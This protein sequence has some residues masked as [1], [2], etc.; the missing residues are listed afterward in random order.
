MRRRQL[1]LSISNDRSYKRLSFTSQT[2]RTNA[3]SIR[4]RP[5]TN[6]PVMKT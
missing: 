2:A 3:E 4:S 5:S 6:D 1:C